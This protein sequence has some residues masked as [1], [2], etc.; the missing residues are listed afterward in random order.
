MLTSSMFALWIVLA[1]SIVAAFNIISPAAGTAL[2][3]SAS[4]IE[5][6]WTYG[7]DKDASQVDLSFVG[8]SFE[9]NHFCYAIAQNISIEDCQYTWVPTNKRDA[10]ASTTVILTTSDDYGFIARLH[11]AN[12][13]ISLTSRESDSQFSVTGYPYVGAAATLQPDC[14]AALLTLA[15][16]SI[17]LLLH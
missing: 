16:I 12:S 4:A 8:D 5:I 11:D 17:V 7:R 10:L 9:G 14:G 2:N 15:S 13:S 3:L 1:A 6:Q